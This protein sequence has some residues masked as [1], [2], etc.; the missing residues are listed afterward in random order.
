MLDDG[1]L[2]ERSRSG[3]A[4][5]LESLF[6]RYLPWL[7]AVGELIDI[8]SGAAETA[9]LDVFAQLWRERQ[10]PLPPAPTPRALLYARVRAEALRLRDQA[11]IA[12]P[13]PEPDAPGSTNADSAPAAAHAARARP[14]DE[15]GALGELPLLPR[16]AFALR[17]LHG[18][19][20]VE[21]AAVLETP[22]SEVRAHCADAL[23]QLERLGGEDPGAAGETTDAEAVSIP[24]MLLHRW[25]PG[26]RW[27]TDEAWIRLRAR[28]RAQNGRGSGSLWSRLRRRRDAL[29]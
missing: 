26:A 27:D 3:D 4:G 2:L 22:V 21:V 29:A 10:A 15:L 1:V 14:D 23:R 28:L 6:R 18:L 16:L 25:H 20:D 13:A 5:A 19:D 17:T 11:R 24:R 8:P 12:G 9:A 7:C